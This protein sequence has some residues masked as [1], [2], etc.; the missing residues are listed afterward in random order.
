[1]QINKIGVLD[2][3]VVRATIDAA[4]TSVP[5]IGYIRQRP[6]FATAMP[7]EIEVSRRPAI[8]D[9]ISRPDAAAEVPADICRNVGTNPIA[10]NIPRPRARPIA[11]AFTKTRLRNSSR[12]MIGSSARVSVITN[13]TVAS[14]IP[15]AHPHVCADRQPCALSPPKSAKKIRQVVAMERKSTPSTS[16]GLVAFLVGS[17]RAAHA[18]INAAMPIGILM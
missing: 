7:E 2:V 6:V 3:S 9:S 12:G 13:A 4:V 18:T 5:T 17:F 11:V 15:R 14:S 1:M 16:M 10:A 8:I